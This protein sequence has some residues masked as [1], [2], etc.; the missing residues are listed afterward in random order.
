MV[1]NTCSQVMSFAKEVENKAADFYRD[2]SKRFIKEKD[3]CSGSFFASPI[4]YSGNQ[5]MSVPLFP[6]T[7]NN[8]EYS[9]CSVFCHNSRG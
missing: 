4:K 1:L 2:L 7:P 5:N 9:H 8:S 6:G 3:F